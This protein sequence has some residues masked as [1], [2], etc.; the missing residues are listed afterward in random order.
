MKIAQGNAFILVDLRGSIKPNLKRLHILP[1]M[2]VRPTLQGMLWSGAGLGKEIPSPLLYGA[3]GRNC[4]ADQRGAVEDQVPWVE[5][6][7]HGWL[8]E[9]PRCLMGVPYIQGQGEVRRMDNAFF[10]GLNSNIVGTVGL[11]LVACIGI[12]TLILG[13]V[14]GYDVYKKFLNL[15]NWK[16]EV[17]P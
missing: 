5:A 15:S 9:P 8:K 1:S 3:V 12:A 4:R 16:N 11:A 6:G 17:K 2:S 13:T 14:I 10:I 7:F